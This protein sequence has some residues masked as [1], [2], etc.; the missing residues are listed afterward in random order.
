MKPYLFPVWLAFVLVALTP[1]NNAYSANSLADTYDTPAPVSLKT[2]DSKIKDAEVNTDLDEASKTRLLR[3]YRKT[4]W[5][6]EKIQSNNAAT[7][8][9]IRSRKTDPEQ[10]TRIRKEL[11][12]RKAKASARTED[13]ITSRTAFAEME[14]HLFTENANL[15]AVKA[16]LSGLEQQLA[17][18]GGKAEYGTTTVNRS[19]AWSGGDYCSIAKTCVRRRAAGA[20]GSHPL[21]VANKTISPPYPD[22]NARSGVAQSADA[23]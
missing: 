13:I 7:N 8:A 15:A 3:I 6:L 9:F 5:D 2:L 14:Q 1:F 11:Q 18:A 22:Q 10:A 19:K 16:K 17:L 21:D 12:K 4:I 23:H 20:V